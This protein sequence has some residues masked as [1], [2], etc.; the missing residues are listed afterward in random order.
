MLSFTNKQNIYVFLIK[1]AKNG[2]G[3][4]EMRGR[5]TSSFIKSDQYSRVS[6][7]ITFMSQFIWG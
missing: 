4:D 2:V 1:Q 7:F 3:L 5:G 6:K